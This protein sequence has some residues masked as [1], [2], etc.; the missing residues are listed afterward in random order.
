MEAVGVDCWRGDDCVGLGEAACGAL[1]E[2][3]YEGGMVEACFLICPPSRLLH[4]LFSTLGPEPPDPNV[5]CY[6]TPSMLLVFTHLSKSPTC[7]MFS[8]SFSIDII[9]LRKQIRIHSCSDCCSNLVGG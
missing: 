8:F 2:D 3:G 4:R 9:I 6:V 5:T 1:D 7:A